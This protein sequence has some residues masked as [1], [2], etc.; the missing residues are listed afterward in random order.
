MMRIAPPI[1]LLRVGVS[2]KIIHT[3]TGASTVSSR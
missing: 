3:Q 2:E 1:R